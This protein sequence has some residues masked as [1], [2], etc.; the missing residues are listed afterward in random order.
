VK[1]EATI[2]RRYG[3][4]RLTDRKSFLSMMTGIAHPLPASGKLY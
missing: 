2:S 1:F 4:G 3:V